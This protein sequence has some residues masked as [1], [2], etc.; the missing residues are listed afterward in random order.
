LLGPRYNDARFEA[1]TDSARKAMSA[2]LETQK[3]ARN[4]EKEGR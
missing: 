4:A 3:A 2:C 1:A